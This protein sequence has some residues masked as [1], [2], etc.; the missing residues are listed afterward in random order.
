MIKRSYSDIDGIFL[1]NISYMKGTKKITKTVSL[2]VQCSVYTG[3]Y[4]LIYLPPYP[5]SHTLHTLLHIL[6][7]PSFT[8][9]GS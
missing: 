9:P 2:A 7:I 3:V 6:Y 5:H 1:Y 4:T 8:T